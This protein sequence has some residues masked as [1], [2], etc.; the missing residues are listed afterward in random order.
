MNQLQQEN[1]GQKHT[2]AKKL[3]QDE[4]QHYLV[5]TSD[6]RISMRVLQASFRIRLSWNMEVKSLE[7][8]TIPSEH[9]LGLHLEMLMRVVELVDRAKEVTQTKDWP[10]WLSIVQSYTGGKFLT[11]ASFKEQNLKV[12]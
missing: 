5:P 10:C 11:Y 8:Q 4:E 6:G 12:G 3:E 1:K 2:Q 7:E 9:F